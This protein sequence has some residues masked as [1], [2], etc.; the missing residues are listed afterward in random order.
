[1]YFI[2]N[3]ISQDLFVYQPTLATLEFKKKSKVLIMLLVGN[4]EKYITL[5]LS[6]YIVLSCV[7]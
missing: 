7:A 1:M 6:Y 2:S 3:D 4:Q 5:N